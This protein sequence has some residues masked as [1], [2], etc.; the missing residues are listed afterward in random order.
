VSHSLEW[1]EAPYPGSH[2]TLPGQPVFIRNQAAGRM[3]DGTDDGVVTGKTN[4]FGT[5]PFPGW[6]FCRRERSAIT[7]H[8]SS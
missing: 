1:Q 5:Y 3:P 7:S 8:G 6:M 4:L 2:R